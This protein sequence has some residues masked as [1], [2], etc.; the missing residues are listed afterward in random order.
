MSPD[1]GDATFGVVIPGR[2]PAYLPL[3]KVAVVVVEMWETRA[4]SA[5]SKRLC[6]AWETVSSFSMLCIAASFP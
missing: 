6:E 2:S 5:S 4:S 1:V 3:S